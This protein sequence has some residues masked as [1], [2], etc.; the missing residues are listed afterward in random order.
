MAGRVDVK[1]WSGVFP[2]T[3]GDQPSRLADCLARSGA[4]CSM[5]WGANCFGGFVQSRARRKPKS[6]TAAAEAL[7]GPLIKR[8]Q[9]WTWRSEPIALLRFW[10]ILSTYPQWRSR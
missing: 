8:C 1:T 6:V 3:T 10:T 2:P 5:R 4:R 7:E 9:Q